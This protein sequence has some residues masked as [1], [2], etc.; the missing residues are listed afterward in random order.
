MKL[1]PLFAD[2]KGLPVLVVGGGSVARRKVAALRDAGAQV[3]VGA[4]HIDAVSG[5]VRL[6]APRED[7]TPLQAQRGNDLPGLDLLKQCHL[8]EILGAQDVFG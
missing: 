5:V 6:E 2:L 3:R 8:L 4:P 7:F 1:Y